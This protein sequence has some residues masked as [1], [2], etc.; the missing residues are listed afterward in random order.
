MATSKVVVVVIVVVGQAPTNK[1]WKDFRRKR[2]QNLK[3]L[4][5]L[6]FWCV[7][8]CWNVVG[9]N[10]FAGNLAKLMIKYNHHH[11]VIEQGGPGLPIPS[12]SQ[13]GGIE[14]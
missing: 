5:L 1:L 6:I 7:C 10:T 14:I 3:Q 12:K 2:C 13:L 9:A 4:N 8:V 11:K